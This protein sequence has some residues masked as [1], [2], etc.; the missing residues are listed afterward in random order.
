MIKIILIILIVFLIIYSF[1]KKKYDFFSNY[2]NIIFL[3][4]VQSCQIILN[5]HKEYFSKMEYQE[6]KIRGCLNSRNQYKNKVNNCNKHYCNNIMDFTHLEIKNIKYCLQIIN[7][8]YEKYFKKMLL[9]PWNFIKVSRNIEGGMPH[10][11]EKCIVLPENFLDYLN[12]IMI[13]KNKQ[14]LLDNIISTLI[15]EQIH[16]FQRMNYNIFKE[17]YMKYWNF[18]PCSVQLNHKYTVHQRINPD[19]YDDWCYKNNKEYIYPYVKLKKISN[20]LNDVDSVAIPI[21]NNKVNYNE[22]YNLKNFEIYNNFFCNV[23]QNYHPNEISAILLSDLI[24]SKIKDQNISNCKALNIIQ[25]WIKKY[26]R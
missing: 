26:L 13:S 17:I 25:P 9:L 24:V 20:H 7:E 1:S 23:S 5:N 14:K 4:K 18:I 15:H 6:T 2:N 8:T 12:M 3:D 11:I 21:I 19:G 10:T 16:V 22:I